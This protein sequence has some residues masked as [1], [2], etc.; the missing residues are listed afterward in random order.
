VKLLAV[1]L[2]FAVAGCATEE[3]VSEADKSLFVRAAD[4]GRYGV[5][6]ENA[7]S[8]ETFSKTRQFEG[9]YQLTYEFEPRGERRPVYIY[10]TVSVARSASDAA[11]AEGAERIGILIGLKA[12]GVEEREVRMQPGDEA[13]TL[14]LL[15]KGGKPLG[16]VFTMRDGR[17]TYLLVLTGLYFD[18]AEDWKKLIQPKLQQLAGY[19]PA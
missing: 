14:R 18:D 1:L 17:K 9:S 10:A 7:H 16:N 2:V 12:S 19:S 13:S 4:L 5:R 15:V 6:Y 3:P 11:F 8:Y